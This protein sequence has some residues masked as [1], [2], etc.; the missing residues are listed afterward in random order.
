MH[1]H[2][3]EWPDLGWTFQIK[4]SAPIDCTDNKRIDLILP[5]YFTVARSD[6]TFLIVARS[7]YNMGIKPTYS[8]TD[9]PI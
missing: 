8:K 9:H 2:D 3:C 4:E 1:M 7:I 6:A 5:T